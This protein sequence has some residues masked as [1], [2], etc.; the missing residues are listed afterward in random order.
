MDD[1]LA[2]AVVALAVPCRD[3]WSPHW[4]GREV[5]TA[6]PDMF[7]SHIRCTHLHSHAGRL[8]PPRDGPSVSRVK[9][10]ALRGSSW[11]QGQPNGACTT[12]CTPTQGTEARSSTD[13]RVA[14]W[15]GNGEAVVR[16]AD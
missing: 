10:C 16:R 3:S 12:I 14:R 11:K 5:S 6:Q 1:A 4:C 13:G 2:V 15:H 7:P 9:P 8:V